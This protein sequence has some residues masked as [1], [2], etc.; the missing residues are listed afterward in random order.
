MLA[1]QQ[2]YV[3]QVAIATATDPRDAPKQ[4]Q[5]WGDQVSPITRH[6]NQNEPTIAY[7]KGTGSR[8]TAEGRRDTLLRYRTCSKNAHRCKTTGRPC[9]ETSRTMDSG[10]VGRMC[11]R[12]CRGLVPGQLRVTLETCQILWTSPV[13]RESHHAVPS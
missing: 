1:E 2:D 7:R 9:G 11:R 6:T 13:R 3:G 8:S 5:P 10:C 12:P 4:Q